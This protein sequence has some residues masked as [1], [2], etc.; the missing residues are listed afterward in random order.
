MKKIAL[1]L[2]S[3]LAVVPLFAAG[4]SESAFPDPEKTIT[5]VVPHAAG[6]STDL[7]FRA[8]V[9]DLKKVT[10][11]NFIVTNIPG[12]GSATG[13]NEV[14]NGSADGYTLLGSGTHTTA[15]TMQGLTEG[16]KA[17]DYIAALN[18]DPFI[19]AVRND[20]PW[21]SLKELET[22]AKTNP[23][24]ITFGNAGMGGATGVASVGINLAFNKV[25]N[26]TPF[27][28]GADLI[29]S[30]LGGHCDVGIFSQS[31][32][33]ANKASLRPLAI[34]GEKHSSIP[35]L[36]DV[37]TIS[38]AGYPGLSIPSGSFRS[39]TVKKGTPEAVKKWL[40]DAVEKAFYSDGFQKFMNSNG[41][42]QSFHKLD[43]FAAYDATIIAD[44][45]PILKEAGLYKM[46]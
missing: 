11:Q 12:A 6:G 31:E 21:K 17:L 45:E 13:T 26:V 41:F 19:I 20:K 15:A 9:E 4:S 35:D 14:I 27:K 30:V 22:A 23:G 7:I 28:G 39:L 25:F 16:Y 43:D 3:A 18:W 40:A 37:P 36:A 24:K 38:E 10:G 5:I 1:M 46:K 34:L 8:L 42:I 32:V 2:L 33:K 29:A 44:Y